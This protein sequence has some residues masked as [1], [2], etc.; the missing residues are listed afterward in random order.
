[1]LDFSFT[2]LYKFL[3]TLYSI[4]LTHKCSKYKRE[5]EKKQPVPA[6][7]GTSC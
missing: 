7:S 6:P 5:H 2:E 4:Y 1:M 3:L